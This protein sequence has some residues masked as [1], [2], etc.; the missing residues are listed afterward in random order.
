MKRSLCL[1]ILLVCSAV[2][3][4]QSAFASFL[5]AFNTTLRVAATPCP[6][7]FAGAFTRPTCYV[8][9]YDDFFD[10]KER[11]VPLTFGLA[12]SSRNSYWRTV[13]LSLEDDTAQAFRSSLNL[14]QGPQLTVT[15]TQAFIVLELTP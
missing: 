11:F 14:R 12:N 10:F 4:Q 3:A 9:D 8:H 6:A 15:Y 13:S 7:A 1:A 2:N 5:D